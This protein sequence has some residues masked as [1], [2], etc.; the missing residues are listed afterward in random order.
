[1]AVGAAERASQLMDELAD[2][3]PLAQDDTLQSF[4]ISE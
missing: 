1:V 2:T 4:E 3:G